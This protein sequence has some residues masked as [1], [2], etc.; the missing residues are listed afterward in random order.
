MVSSISSAIMQ[1][2]Y[3][4][5]LCGIWVFKLFHAV[6]PIECCLHIFSFENIARFAQLDLEW[7]QNINAHTDNTESNFSCDNLYQGFRFDDFEL[8]VSIL[9]NDCRSQKGSASRH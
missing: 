2:A 1:F 5:F 3:K 8:L 4:F 9:E 7:F 6:T